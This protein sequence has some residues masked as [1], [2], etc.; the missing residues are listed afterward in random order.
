MTHTAR[1]A[2]PTQQHAVLPRLTV[3]IVGAGP[4][5]VSV[6][7][8][9]SANARL[10]VPDKQ[11]TV[12]IVDP[13]RPG[14][15][16]V[17]R[18]WQSR[19]L[20][21]NTVASQVTLFT[22]KSVD[23]DGPVSPGPS[24]HEWADLLILSG[25]IDRYDEATRAEA[26]RL[27]PDSYPT[28]AF[29]GTYLEWVFRRIVRTAPENMSVVV[30]CTNA[31][32]LDDT[33]E[34]LTEQ[35]VLLGNGTRLTKLDA[36]VLAQGHLP[37][38]LTAT[39]KKLGA[40]AA[41]QGITYVPPANPADVDLSAIP[42]GTP[43]L[44]RGLGLNFFD[45]M[46]L[47]TVGRGGRFENREGTMVYRPSGGEPRIHAGSRRGI[48]YQARGENEKGAHGRHLPILLTP[49]TIERL[50][51]QA[52][53]CGG[54]DFARDLWPLVSAEVEIVYYTTLLAARGRHRAAESFT[55]R[56]LAACGQATKQRRGVRP[57]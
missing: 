14:A 46:A 11:I 33:T 6:L 50:Q 54:L 32:T 1:T 27:G 18:T 20:L 48:P 40:F 17:W 56:Y 22:D 51:E 7:E 53:R 2:F 42:A 13:Y 43:V 38:N 49:K 9:I 28:R 39:E 37:T 52:A 10:L 15:G 55:V 25:Q 4:R 35:T 21:M 47:L 19:H 36:V 16:Q 30:H 29:Y 8:R 5:G 41:A 3:C 31:L 26:R 24:L 34:S 44:L 23:I 57:R 45:Y 12:H